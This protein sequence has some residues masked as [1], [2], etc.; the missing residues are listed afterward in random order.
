M[1]SNLFFTSSLSLS[2]SLSGVPFQPGRE[3]KVHQVHLQPS[4]VVKS[5]SSLRGSGHLGYPLFHTHCCEGLWG[6][7]EEERESVVA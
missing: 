4:S 5:C 6:E 7:G 2:V 1:I 3:V